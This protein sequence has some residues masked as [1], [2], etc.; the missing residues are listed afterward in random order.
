MDPASQIFFPHK[1][2][3]E[4]SLTLKFFCRTLH[5]ST[6]PSHCEIPDADGGKTNQSEGI[7]GM[8]FVLTWR[9]INP[10]TVAGIM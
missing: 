8:I 1:F 10:H 9:K 7:L 2:F 6:G 4:K 5:P 3:L